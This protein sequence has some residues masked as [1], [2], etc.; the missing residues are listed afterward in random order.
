MYKVFNVQ[1]YQKLISGKLA[2]VYREE[3]YMELK[4]KLSKLE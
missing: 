2:I 1:G 3:E 4:Y